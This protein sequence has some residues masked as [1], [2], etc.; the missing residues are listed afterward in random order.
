VFE[1]SGDEVLIGVDGGATEVKVHAVRALGGS[2][3]LELA[4]PSAAEVYEIA[5][6]FR[7][8]RMPAQLFALERGT[9]ETKGLEGAQA[10][11][12]L[13]AATR[14]I[15]SVSEQSGQARVRLGVCMPGLKTADGRGIAVLRRGPRVPDYLDRLAVLLQEAGLVLAR[16]V[17]RLSSDG[18]ACAVGEQFEPRGALRGVSNAYYLGGGTGVAEALVVEGKILGFDFLANFARKAWQIEAPGGH[19]VEDLISPRGINTAY[20]AVSG[21][22]QPLAAEDFPER[23]ALA[24]DEN[25]RSVLFAAYEALA[26]L[27]VDRMVALRRGYQGG[28]P[29]PRSPTDSPARILPNTFLDRI[30]IGQRLGSILAAEDLAGVFRRPAEEALARRI[31]ASGDGALRKHYLAGS[32]LREGL[33]VP[34][35]LRAAPAIGAVAI[36]FAEA[37]TRVRAPWDAEESGGG[38]TS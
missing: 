8:E 21:K 30:V 19:V 22:S 35:L 27:I 4:G 7:P 34:S 33:L 1:H 2:D 11:L 36:E 37:P 25:A 18:E 3:A 31:V 10:R 32:S 16:P 23:R 5:R 38:A 26:G 12:W 6:G 9:I 29:F 20:A 15:V 24:G 14:S 17:L 28:V 13:E